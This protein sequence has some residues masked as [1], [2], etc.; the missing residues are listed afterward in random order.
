MNNQKHFYISAFT[1][2]IYDFF[3]F[4]LSFKLDYDGVK[5]N[6][7]LEIICFVICLLGISMSSSLL[8]SSMPIIWKRNFIAGVAYNVLSDGVGGYRSR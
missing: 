1:S 4:L 8:Y 3:D 6:A 2:L 5:F 7:L